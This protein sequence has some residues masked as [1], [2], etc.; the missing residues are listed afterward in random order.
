M[1][2]K[3][4]NLRYIDILVREE[5]RVIKLHKEQVNHATEE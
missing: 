5:E 3:V 2:F 4:I 1:S